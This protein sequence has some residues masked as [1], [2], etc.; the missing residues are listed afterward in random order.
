MPTLLISYHAQWTY[1]IVSKQLSPPQAAVIAAVKDYS[2]VTA[3]FPRSGGKGYVARKCAMTYANEHPGAQ[4]LVVCISPQESYKQYNAE[5]VN[6]NRDFY[7]I[8]LHNGSTILFSNHPSPSD[9][10][11]F[12]DVYP[13]YADI[14][15]G[16]FLF[17]ATPIVDMDGKAD[18]F[19]EIYN[20]GFDEAFPEWISIHSTYL[21]CTHWENGE[22][23]RMR[24]A[25][26]EKAFKEDFEVEWK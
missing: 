15:R 16:K 1:M 3:A 13:N 21:D 20:R 17:L 9:F 7:S 14:D 6:R 19:T 23:D 2:Y 26:S 18:I 8:L 22:V 25:I 11:I 12:D 10:T 5:S 24:V 4:V